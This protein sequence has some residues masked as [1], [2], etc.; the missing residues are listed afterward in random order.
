MITKDE[1]EPKAQPTEQD[2]LVIGAAYQDWLRQTL[3]EQ[4][5]TEGKQR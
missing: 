3:Q 4:D 2:W 1:T 5:P